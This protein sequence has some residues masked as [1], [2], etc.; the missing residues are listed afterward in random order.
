MPIRETYLQEYQELL[1]HVIDEP[2]LCDFIDIFLCYNALLNVDSN[3]Q[4]LLYRGQA[5]KEYNLTPS[6]FRNNM[7]RHES[8]MINE[9]LMQAPEEFININNPF[10]KLIKM[11]HY[12]LP[13]RLLDV[14]MNPLVALYFACEKDFESDGEVLIMRE[15]LERPDNK[16]VQW[17]SLLAEYDGSS[18]HEMRDFYTEA[19]LLIRGFI[20][21]GIKEMLEK[22]VI[23]VAAPK[24]NE[25]IKRQHGAFLLFG[26]D[27]NTAINIYKKEAF[28][29]KEQVT[30]AFGDHIKRSIIIPSEIKPRL[31]AE[32][33]TIG[34]N[35]SFLYPE[36]EHQT[37]YI[38]R[39]YTE[40]V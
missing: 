25:R 39:K 8:K 32:L 30:S 7:L 34:I 13:T 15:Y 31:I 36:L 35:K 16:N 2:A 19:G 18:E 22:R 28:D 10:E 26:H 29:I 6:I 27:I 38:M 17:L 33:N 21:V 40:E 12:G 3:N 14:T 24:N 4:V 5:N 20:T 23:P 11:Q 1:G 9:L 37:N